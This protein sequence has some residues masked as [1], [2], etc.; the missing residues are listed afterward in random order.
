MKKNYTTLLIV[1][2]LLLGCR[3][4]AQTYTFI[5][6]GAWSSSSNWDSI[7]IPPNPLPTGQTII[8]DGTAILDI[9]QTILSSVPT[10]S[11]LAINTS[12]TLTIN[13]SKT[14]INQGNLTNNG[15]LVNDGTIILFNVLT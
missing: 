5:G 8:I 7:G 11:I 13:P 10:A 14:L 3:C 6:T 9:D 12:K 2:I 15:T 1:F 4:F